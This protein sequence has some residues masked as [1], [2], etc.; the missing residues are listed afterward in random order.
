MISLKVICKNENY[1][2]VLVSDKNYS[3]SWYITKGHTLSISLILFISNLPV[4]L[5][6]VFRYYYLTSLEPING[7]SFPLKPN[8]FIIG[9]D[10]FLSYF[11]SNFSWDNS[12]L[13]IFTFVFLIWSVLISS[14]IRINILKKIDN[15]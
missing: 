6:L 15:Y 4:T 7:V 11:L 1:K 14:S 2:N 9:G 5:F 10:S 8:D 3:K 13:N 12:V